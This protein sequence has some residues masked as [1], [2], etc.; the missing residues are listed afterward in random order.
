MVEISLNRDEVDTL[1]EVVCSEIV[2]IEGNIS[3]DQKVD[4]TKKP[5]LKV[6]DK[7]LRKLFIADR[8]MRRSDG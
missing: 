7:I 6:L 2:G 4:E 3:P 8:D 1:M 5:K